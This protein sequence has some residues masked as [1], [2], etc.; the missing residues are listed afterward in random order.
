[1]T[2]ESVGCGTTN[3]GHLRNQ[4]CASAVR[5]AYDAERPGVGIS[6]VFDLVFVADRTGFSTP[7]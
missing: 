1:M 6:S 7:D 5:Q 2:I 3:N 4:I